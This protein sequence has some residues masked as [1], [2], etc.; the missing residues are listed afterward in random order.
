[1]SLITSV[2]SALSGA[3]DGELL[4][5]QIILSRGFLNGGVG[6]HV[7]SLKVLLHVVVVVSAL[8][9]RH[10]TSALRNGS[11]G[12]RRGFPK[13]RRLMRLS[14]RGKKRGFPGAKPC[15]HLQPWH[16]AFPNA[17]CRVLRGSMRP[18]RMV[19]LPPAAPVVAQVVLT[20]ANDRIGFLSSQ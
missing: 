12:S 20:S 10:A 18:V 15:S 2:L 4:P 3:W 5:L 17:D 16:H 13:S 7:S 11:T 19:N 9:V 8:H 1:M 6:L 14:R